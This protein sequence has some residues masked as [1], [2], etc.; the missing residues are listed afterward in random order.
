M[1]EQRQFQRGD[2]VTHPRRP[3]WGRGIVK[4]AARIT[5]RG[6]PAQR[7][8]VQ[9]ANKGRVVINTAVAPLAPEHE[10]DKAASRFDRASQQVTQ[11]DTPTN[12]QNRSTPP[13]PDAG[14]LNELENRRGPG[15]AALAE[16]PEAMTDPFASFR[17]RLEATLDSYRFTNAPRSLIDWAVAQSGHEDPLSHYTRHELEEA[18][19]RFTRERD[20]HL[21]DLVRQIKTK[22]EQQLL[23]DALQ[24]TRHDKARE[25]LRKLM[26]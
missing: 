22:G 15:A 23:R 2:V 16:L 25:R 1:A 13:V 7:V 24:S 26:R 8:A 6:S 4:D 21:Q 19:E 12:M 18:F 17:R 5:Y 11:Q 3:E 10:A 9:F 20:R 14:W